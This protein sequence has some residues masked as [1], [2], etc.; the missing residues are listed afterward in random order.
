MR[1][2]ILLF[3]SKSNISKTIRDRDI[4]FEGGDTEWKPVT[5][6][7]LAA[8]WKESYEDPDQQRKYEKHVAKESK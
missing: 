8:Q 6:A 4:R 5:A 1:K 2:N 7:L 3:L